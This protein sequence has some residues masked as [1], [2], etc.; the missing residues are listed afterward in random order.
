MRR[1]GSLGLVLPP[2][3]SY[4]SE[5]EATRLADL[6]GHDLADTPVAGQEQLQA[7]RRADVTPRLAALAGIP[8]LIVLARHD[9]IA[10]PSIGPRVNGESAAC[11]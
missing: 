6:F 4:D 7:L 8:T 3:R 2:G 10:P 11:S 9:P 5:R 1:R